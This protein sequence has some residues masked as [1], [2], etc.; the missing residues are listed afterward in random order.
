MNQSN[1]SS[2]DSSSVSTSSPDGASGKKKRGLFESFGPAL[3]VAS[4]V[5]GP[6][7]IYLASAIGV[8]FG[9]SLLWVPLLSTALMICLVMISARLGVIYEQTLCEELAQRL[10]RPVAVFVGVT[11][12][13]I[14]ASFQTGNNAA[15]LFAI[16]PFLEQITGRPAGEVRGSG[17]S[18]MILLLLN[19]FILA[20]LFGFKKLYSPVEK[21]LIVLVMIMM[22]GFFVNLGFARPSIL[23]IGQGL[24]PNI[25]QPAEG[26]PDYNWT[27]VIGFFATSVSIAGAFYQSYL[28]KE[29]GWG[30]KDIKQ[31]MTDSL[32]GIAI[33]G[34][35]SAVIMITAAEVL[36]GTVGVDE[37]G[38]AADVGR[39]L[40]PFFGAASVVLF[41]LGLF[42]GAFSSFLVNAMIGGTIL[43]DGLGLGGRLDQTSTRAFTAFALLFGMTLALLFGGTAP[44]VI[45]T[46]AQALTVFGLPVLALVMLYLVTRPD[47]TGPR[48]VPLWMKI[49]LVIGCVVV[50]LLAIRTGIN[51]ISG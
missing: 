31:G 5:L 3:I 4:V 1:E 41:S 7:S 35:V 13:L 37:I 43:A 25:P 19:G 27:L 33:L 48:A 42:A 21:F 22:I 11:V 2:P 51:L 45:I 30:I 16:D 15:I 29:K 39:Q 38:T 14:V 49:V 40:E 32:L 18:V 8:E 36:F 20:V 47:L 23:S 50:I 28:V 9:Y 10:G 26:A 46:F 12:F 17:M 44:A 34:I 24:I 6:G